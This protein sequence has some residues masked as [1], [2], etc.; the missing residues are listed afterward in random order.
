MQIGGK[1]LL[2]A[3]DISEFKPHDLCGH[4]KCYSPDYRAHKL[5]MK[6]FVIEMFVSYK[7]AY[8]LFVFNMN[9][10]K[11][12]VNISKPVERKDKEELC[13]S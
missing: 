6:Q 11:I 7:S 4:E 1:L 5:F 10:N 13:H 8:S 3:F 9:I 2:K 12:F